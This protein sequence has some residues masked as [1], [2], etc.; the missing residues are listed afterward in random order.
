[1]GESDDKLYVHVQ[2]CVWSDLPTVKTGRRK[3]LKRQDIQEYFFQSI[4]I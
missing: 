1:M 4:V 2:N 3:S